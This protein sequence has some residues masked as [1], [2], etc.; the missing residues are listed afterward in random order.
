MQWRWYSEM[1]IE[2]KKRDSIRERDSM[3][4]L[5]SFW[6]SEAVSKIREARDRAAEH[7]FPTDEEF[8]KQLLDRT[9]KDNEYLDVAKKL[10]EDNTNF[11]SRNRRK[12]RGPTDLSAIS[13]VAGMFNLEE[14]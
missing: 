4:Y 7:N 13:K 12:T 9:Y 6:N 8:E 10:V 1:I 14:D 11:K 2:E 5:A 3:E